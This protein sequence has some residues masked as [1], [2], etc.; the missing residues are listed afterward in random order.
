MFKNFDNFKGM[1]EEE[2]EQFEEELLHDIENV[3]AE[4]GAYGDEIP[5]PDVET[6]I[7]DNGNSYLE[8]GGGN[9]AGAVN[10]SGPIELTDEMANSVAGAI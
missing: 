2:Q 9:G 4:L 3:S 6:A 7:N 5:N 1:S 10:T 8:N